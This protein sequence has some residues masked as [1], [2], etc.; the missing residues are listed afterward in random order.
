MPG[1]AAERARPPKPIDPY[2]CSRRAAVVGTF[3]GAALGVAV[4]SKIKKGSDE[5]KLVGAL[6]GGVLGAAIGH[7]IDQRKCALKQIAAQN[8][9][10]LT[11]EPISSTTLDGALASTPPVGMSVSIQES[12]E[13]FTSN[14]DA[15]TPA[16]ERY[17]S[18]IADTY[19]YARQAAQVPVDATPEQRA[20]VE[21]L[22]GKVILLVGHTDDTG[23]SALNAGLSERRAK[24]VASLFARRGVPLPQVYYQ[25]AGETLPIAD[26]RT[27][28]GRRSNRRVEIIDLPDTSALAAYLN[29]RASRPENFR[30]V[31]IAAETTVDVLPVDDPK[32]VPKG[33]RGRPS[34][35]AV[36]RAPSAGEILPTQPAPQPPTIAQATAAPGGRTSAPNPGEFNFGGRPVASLN[37]PAPTIGAPL[38]KQPG[39]PVSR[40]NAA[41][42]S[43]L[44]ACMVDR[45]RV[46][47]AV[48]SLATGSEAAFA[49]RDF[50]PGLYGTTWSAVVNGQLLGLSRVSVL[51]DGGTPVTRPELL[52]YR[53]FAKAPDAR[54]RPEIRVRPH[55]NVYRGNRGLLYRVFTPGAANLRCI[56]MVLPADGGFS[57]PGSQLLYTLNGSSFVADFSPGVRRQ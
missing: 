32:P 54:R 46:A 24:A 42:A 23:S 8:D 29:A 36:A 10:K 26:N 52:I 40:A 6:I 45:P 19:V 14:S 37:V 38:R 49:V 22:Q 44:P 55:V 30:P 17:F 12:P 47:Y 34:R 51:R 1:E 41:S 57:A 16:A 13:Q 15:L 7:E 43:R 48:K 4:G 33:K 3:V 27:E 39:I 5:A 25:G 28:D 2:S 11:Y 18:D 9:L 21:T 53:D 31:E 56:D 20:G 35:P 50:I